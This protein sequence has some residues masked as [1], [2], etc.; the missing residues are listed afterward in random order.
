MSV[1]VNVCLCFS[2]IDKNISFENS[3]FLPFFSNRNIGDNI[4]FAKNIPLTFASSFSSLLSRYLNRKASIA[5]C[6]IANAHTEALEQPRV[7]QARHSCIAATAELVRHGRPGN[8]RKQHDAKNIMNVCECITTSIR[9]D[10]KRRD[11]A[12]AKKYI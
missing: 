9:D 3:F 4:F 10:D 8:H 6:R 1:C 2:I 12:K 11:D 7:A 5:L